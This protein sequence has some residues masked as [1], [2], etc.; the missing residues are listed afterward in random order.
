MCAIEAT[1]VKQSE[2]QFC[3]RWSGLVALSTSSGP[4][5]STPSSSAG[6]VTLDATNGIASLQRCFDT[7]SA[8]LYQVNTCVDH[9]ARRQAHLGGFV[10]SPSPPPE[11]SKAS[12]DD[13]DSNND[14]DDG[15]GDG[16]GDVSSS[17]SDEMS[18]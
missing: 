3:S 12:E 11:A 4:S 2:A 18:T 13:D 7:L 1:T 14:D 16:D 17:S 6:G 9:I 10:E 5:T 15:D 8:E